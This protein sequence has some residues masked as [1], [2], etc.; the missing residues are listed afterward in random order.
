MTTETK[1]IATVGQ[2][3]QAFTTLIQQREVWEAAMYASSNAELYAL[4]GRCLDMLAKVK[5]FTELARGLNGLLKKRGFKFTDGTSAEVKLLRAVFGDPSEPNKYKQR[6]YNYARVL[7]VAHS[8]GITGDQLPAFISE[9]GGIDEIRR[10]DPEASKKSNAEKG[11]RHQAEQ[12]LKD[13]AFTPLAS[14]LPMTKA[15]VPPPC[16]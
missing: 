12:K 15:L 7:T 10:H 4:L 9:K 6:I 14:G 2:L 8:E 13:A 5:R 11:F 16:Q 3:D 1:N